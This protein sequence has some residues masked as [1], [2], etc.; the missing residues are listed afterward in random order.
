[1]KNKGLLV[2]IILVL[3]FCGIGAAWGIVKN[4]AAGIWEFIKALPQLIIAIAPLTDLG[5][6]I[7]SKII[8]TVIVC[9]LSWTGF[10]LSTRR[11]RKLLAVISGIVGFI[12]TISLLVGLGS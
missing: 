4:I 7:K 5:D 8:F 12:S 2:L 10:V 11:K 9:L 3:V 6:W 1:M